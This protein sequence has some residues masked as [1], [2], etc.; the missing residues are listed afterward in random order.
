MLQLQ[1]TGREKIWE[2]EA[3]HLKR[4][5]AGK[6]R[7]TNSM[8]SEQEGMLIVDK[9]EDVSQYQVP[10][11]IEPST[12]ATRHIATKFASEQRRKLLSDSRERSLRPKKRSQNQDPA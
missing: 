5:E 3:G 2:E 6:R 1:H 4:L 8:E 10:M 7:L 9:L 11:A 12:V